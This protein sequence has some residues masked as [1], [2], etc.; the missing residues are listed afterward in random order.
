MCVCVCVPAA[1]LMVPRCEDVM[2]SLT[3]PVLGAVGVELQ[4]VEALW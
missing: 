3:H 2:C 4:C 1:R